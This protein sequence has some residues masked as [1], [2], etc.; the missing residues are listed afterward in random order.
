MTLSMT[1]T[2]CARC[3]AA[4]PA[5]AACVERS[6]RSSAHLSTR[7]RAGFDAASAE[8]S[9]LAARTGQEAPGSCRYRRSRSGIVS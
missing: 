9:L 4:P 2:C 1:T 7:D 6:A 8:F 5:D 3:W